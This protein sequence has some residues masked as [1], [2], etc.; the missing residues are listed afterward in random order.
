M[1]FRAVIPV[2]RKQKQGALLQGQGHLGLRKEF[3][4][5]QGYMER[6]CLKIN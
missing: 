6:A 2:L 5:N 3:Q 4:A 1:V